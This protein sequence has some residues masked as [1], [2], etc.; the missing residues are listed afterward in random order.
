MAASQWPGRGSP[1]SVIGGTIAHVRTA[2]A[3]EASPP[4]GVTCDPGSPG[5]N[6]AL[7]GPQADVGASQQDQL[8][9]VLAVVF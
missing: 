8:R 7:P 6:G 3:S 2:R 9:V 5:A 4:L 1:A